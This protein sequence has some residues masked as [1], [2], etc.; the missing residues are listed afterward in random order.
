MPPRFTA[1]TSG[2]WRCREGPNSFYLRRQES[3]F[4]PSHALRSAVARGGSSAPE[5]SMINPHRAFPSWSEKCDP[6]PSQRSDLGPT[7]DSHGHQQPGPARCYIEQQGN[8]YF[9]EV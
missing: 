6:S 4:S 7:N 3:L 9:S 5:P 2:D 8:M 1:A